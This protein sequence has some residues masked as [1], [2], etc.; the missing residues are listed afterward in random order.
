MKSPRDLGYGFPVVAVLD[1]PKE[2]GYPAT[3]AD[4]TAG[5]GDAT[6]SRCL[7]WLPTPSFD[8]RSVQRSRPPWGAR[9]RRTGGP[10]ERMSDRP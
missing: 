8:L 10:A 9:R 4:S 1:G 6:R 3:R 2:I 7:R 5:L